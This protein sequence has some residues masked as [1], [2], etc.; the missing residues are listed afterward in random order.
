MIV[1]TVVG[2]ARPATRITRIGEIRPY[3]GVARTELE[4]QRTCLV[5]GGE[6]LD[7]MDALV[8]A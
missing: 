4:R 1:S 7:D 5:S 8:G 6:K 3:T 2:F